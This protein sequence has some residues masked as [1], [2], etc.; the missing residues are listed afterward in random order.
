M[1]MTMTIPHESISSDNLINQHRILPK[2][3]NNLTTPHK[4]LTPNQ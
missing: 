2:I 4:N 1:K 3:S